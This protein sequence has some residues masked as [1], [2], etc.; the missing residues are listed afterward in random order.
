MY[1]KDLCLYSLLKVHQI[2]EEMDQE[3]HRGFMLI[4]SIKS[5]WYSEQMEEELL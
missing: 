1:A 2:R 5:V 4:F 3:L